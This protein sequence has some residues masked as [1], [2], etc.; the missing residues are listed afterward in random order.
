MMPSLR[1]NVTLAAKISGGRRR[2]RASTSAA[3]WGGLALYLAELCGARVTG[4]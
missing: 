4:I 3:G 2:A 1:R